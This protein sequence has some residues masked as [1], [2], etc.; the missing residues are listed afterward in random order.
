LIGGANTKDI[1]P[2]A[3]SDGQQVYLDPASPGDLTSTKPDAPHYQIVIG[4]V[5]DASAGNLLVQTTESIS[6]ND[7]GGDGGFN[8]GNVK[9]L[10]DGDILSY[11]LANQRF[12]NIVPSG[13]GGFTVGKTV[14]VD[15]TAV[16]SGALNDP[17]DPYLTIKEAITAVIGAGT[18]SAP[19]NDGFTIIVAPGT[20]AE[21]GL[22]LP[23]NT[24]LVSTGG[25]A[26]TII[27]PDPADAVTDILS[28]SE[29]C[30]V[31]G[32]SFNVPG[33]SGV[34]YY[35]S[36]IVA[37]QPGGGPRTNGIYNCNMYGNGG[38]GDSTGF[39]VYRTGGGK[40]IG[41]NIRC[42][43]GGMRS[44]LKVDQG[45]LAL[46]GLHNPESTGS[47]INALET[48]TMAQLAYTPAANFAD[49]DTVQVD[50]SGLVTADLPVSTGSNYTYIFKTILGSPSVNEVHVLLG[51]DVQESLENLIA[52]INNTES[53]AIA[54]AGTKYKYGGSTIVH[55]MVRADLGNSGGS[56][57]YFNSKIG[58]ELGE[59]SEITVTSAT[60]G[61]LP[62]TPLTITTAG[63]AQMVGFNTGKGAAGLPNNSCDNAVSIYGGTASIMPVALVFTPNVFNCET[64]IS[65]DGKYLTVSFIGGRIENV[66][67]AVKVTA[68]TLL[69]AEAE[70][71][72]YRISSN[73][74][75][76]YDYPAE[77]AVYSDFVLN[78][79]QET[80][81]I[82]EASY[83]IFG[84]SQLS[85]GF[86]ER[87][88]S[89]HL[90]RGA[91]YTT[92][93]FVVQDD[94]GVLTDVS[95]AA[96]SKDSSTFTFGAGLA[97]GDALYVASFRKGENE[98]GVIDY[99][100]HWG[101]EVFTNTRE[102]SVG[103]GEY[104]F[105]YYNGSSWTEFNTHA[106]SV[107]EGYSYA[108]NNFWRSD[109]DEYVRYGLDESTT[110]WDTFQLGGGGGFT[111]Y[112]GGTWN[113][114]IYWIRIRVVTA[115]SSSYPLFERF[116]LL[117][118]SANISKNGVAN[119]TGLAQFRKNLALNGPIWSGVSGGGALV[120]NQTTVGSGV[121]AWPHEMNNSTG[122]NAAAEW[123]IQFP[124]PLG[125]CTAHPINISI[126]YEIKYGNTV[127]A[128]GANT[129]DLAVVGLE[130]V[131]NLVAD[132]S[133]AIGPSARTLANTETVITKAPQVTPS[134]VD[135]NS[136]AA[137]RALVIDK[138][139]SAELYSV[140]VSDCYEGDILALQ[141]SLDSK[142]ADSIV[143]WSLVVEGVSHQDGKGI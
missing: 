84:Q 79:S 92:G 53:L 81:D 96:T 12:E 48:T 65:A 118:S 68:T 83:N 14:Y 85:V 78:Y 135:L 128:L 9:A 40:T 94:G 63:R 59:D 97:A 123:M 104:V 131:G 71:A 54:G 106:V 100:K 44:F 47:M 141:L 93:M 29:D 74:Q 21:D 16:G 5:L 49:G 25:W 75:P 58:G 107:K 70:S 19:A 111:P 60:A 45:V 117:D 72:K 102:E 109:S 138:L 108:N 101:I 8:V 3:F 142:D 28:I 120:S 66:T 69:Q 89:S 15:T 116:K 11:N 7:I 6:T 1:T 51:A 41:A 80:T 98:L 18:R 124:I 137:G 50:S 4:N 103:T 87:G 134:P 113:T 32:F 56:T 55:D 61:N 20:Y 17:A 139:H 37:D 77:A 23:N 33:G 39:G 126:I 95:V 90:G 2:P 82:F 129:M 35:L 22:L 36:A 119:A 46:E 143:L 31:N 10:A 42:E 62:T 122:N 127:P 86:S 114:A 133:G 125:T 121:D 64:A 30:Y 105:E 67:T 52:A 99:L 34:E 24:S 88:A 140:D 91:P 27:G 132:P 110:D 115:P 13:G 136:G 38:A 57:I 26:Q 130:V 112:F 43:G 76:I 73:H